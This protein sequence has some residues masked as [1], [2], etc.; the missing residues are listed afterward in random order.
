MMLLEPFCLQDVMYPAN[1]LLQKAGLTNRSF[2][3]MR[4]HDFGE[5]F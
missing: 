5:F 4:F 2:F 1:R 3:E